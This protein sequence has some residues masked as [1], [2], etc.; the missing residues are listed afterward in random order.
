M[1]N[2]FRILLI[3]LFYAFHSTLSAQKTTTNDGAVSITSSRKTTAPFALKFANKTFDQRNNLFSEYLGYREGIDRLEEASVITTKG[4]TTYRYNQYFGRIPIEHGSYSVVVRENK[5]QYMMGDFYQIDPSFNIVP[6]ID[7][8]AALTKALEKINAQ[9]YKWEIP[10]EETFIK[11]ESGDPAATFFPKGELVLVENFESPEELDG[12]LHLAYKF[13]VYSHE[14]VSRF[15]VYVDAQTGEILLKENKIMSCQ[16]ADHVS[17]NL[18]TSATGPADSRYSGNVNIPTQFVGASYRLQADLATEGY[19]LHTY[20]MNNGTNFGSALEITDVDNNWTA[21]EFPN[22]TYDNAALDAHWG[23]AVVYDY[24]KTEHNRFSYDNNNAVILSYVH[25]DV[26]Y[27]NASWDGTRM[28]YGDGSNTPGGFTPLTGLDVCGHEIAHAVCTYTCD[29]VYER[30]SG[31]LN[32]AFSDIWGAATEHKYDPFEVDGDPKDNFLIGE[33]I[34]FNAGAALRSMINPNQ[35]NDP[36]TWHGT[37]WVP[38]TVAEGCITPGSGND[39][40]GVHSNSGVLNHWFYLLVTGGTGTN[41]HGDNYSVTGIG[42]ADAQAIVYQGEISMTSTSDYA[43]CRVAMINAAIALFG[44]CSANVEAVTDAFYAVGV[45]PAFG[46]CNPVIMFVN[47]N[48]FIDETG[49]TGSSCSKTKTINVPVNLSGLPTETAIVLF[50][51]SGS[52]SSGTLGDYTIA[53]NFITFPTGSYGNSNLVFTINDDAIVEGTE[54]IIISIQSIIT[55]GN[56]EAAIINQTCTIHILDD[57]HEPEMG[58]TLANQPIFS[59]DFTAGQGSWTIQNNTGNANQIWRFGNNSGTN[60]Y[61]NS[62]NNCAY[63]SRNSTTFSYNNT[64]GN[65]MLVSPSISTFNIHNVNMTF[66]FVCN[67][68]L[69]NGI[70][71]DYGTL[72]YSIDDGTTWLPINS[73]K[74]T[75]ISTK[76]L[77]T[78]ALPVGADNNTGIR[79]GFLWINDG[80]VILNPPFGVDNIVVKGDIP[81]PSEIESALITSDERYLG[82]NQTVYFYNPANDN[83]LA[84]IQNN[85]A[86]DYGCTTVEVDRTGTSAQFVTGDVSGNNLNKLSDKTYKV[87]PENNSTDGHY[88]ITLYYS[89]DEKDGFETATGRTWIEDNGANNGVKILKYPGSI[90]A[91]NA[92]TGG[93]SNNIDDVG[94][95]NVDGYTASG[96]FSGGFSGFAIGVPPAQVLPVKILEFNC[97]KI[98][99]NVQLNWKVTDEVNLKHYQVERSSDGKSFENIGTVIAYGSKEYQYTDSRPLTGLNYYRIRLVDADNKYDYTVIK[100]VNFGRESDLTIYPNPTTGFIKLSSGGIIQNITVLDQKGLEVYVLN[101]VN[102]NEV[103]ADLKDLLPAVYNIRVVLKDGNVQYSKLIKS[104]K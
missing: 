89:E 54:T 1:P 40:C 64:T 10:G 80:G 100:S 67:G 93:G 11:K 56:V 53:N 33:E 25:F 88:T 87:T 41:D 62:G 48:M 38:A 26:D 85:T 18:P 104:G 35:Y 2:L 78:V 5:I 55:T 43:A 101:N 31:A 60:T 61:F 37:N 103:Q 95:F 66:E 8:N 96:N 72:W 83:I 79:I 28:K 99:E 22:A 45:G 68:E 90:S 97:Y 98:K 9:K 73:T 82:P 51:I 29:L 86:H 7:E 63:F 12:N 94:I 102:A 21:L 77:I 23:A 19:P 39:Q 70:Y 36:D 58:S 16:L 49:T 74:Y 75:G 84:K 65:C 32:E 46:T 13:D 91:I 34:V 57:D 44:D 15:Q 17:E 14:P 30:E 50:N 24:W 59:E 27:N 76:T 69:D 20:D 4:L 42:W 6:A 71:Y 81:F 52:A 47:S 3:V 92:N